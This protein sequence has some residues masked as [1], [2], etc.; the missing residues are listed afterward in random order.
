MKNFMTA[1]RLVIEINSN[2]NV[3]QLTG[4]GYTWPALEGFS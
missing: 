3:R 4:L 2:V 1:D